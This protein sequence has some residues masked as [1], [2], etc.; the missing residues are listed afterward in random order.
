MTDEALQTR[1]TLVV[2]ALAGSAAVTLLGAAESPAATLTVPTV[3]AVT[4]TTPAGQV[5]DAGVLTALL[6]VEQVSAFS[7]AH[8]LATTKL[9]HRVRRVLRDFGAQE[10]AHTAA[11]GAALRAQGGSAPR[12]PRNAKAADEILRALGSPGSLG[13]IHNQ[14]DAIRFLV[15]LETVAEG[16]YWKAMAV[17][18]D[19][20][21]LVTAAQIMAN[22]AQHEIG[23]RVLVPGFKA[24]D[25]APTPFVSGRH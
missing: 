10:R 20:T 25:Y 13:H 18:I 19:P 24:A 14:A 15:G 12:R 17:L 3:P 16:A 6:V 11:I 2:R 4:T 5:S 22:E 8:V 1:R 21:V 23:L 7:Y 9:S